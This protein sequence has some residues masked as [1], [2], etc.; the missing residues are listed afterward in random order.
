MP[1]HATSESRQLAE[2]LMSEGRNSE[3]KR[4]F[5]ESCKVIP[6]GVNSPGRSFRHVGG[7]PCFVD[8]ALGCYLTDADGNRYIDY[9]CSWGVMLLGHADP[10]VTDAIVSAVRN[11][12][13]FGLPSRGELSVAA[14]VTARVPSVEKLRLVNTGTEAV[15]S[16]IRLARAATGRI[17]LLKFAGCYH[18]NV[19]DLLVNTGGDRRGGCRSREA[20]AGGTVTHVLPFNDI[21]GLRR[22]F[23][24]NGRSI[25]AVIVEPVAANMGVVPPAAGFLEEL[26]ILC[27]KY[28]SLLI[29][30]E[31]VTGFRLGPSGAQGT[32]GVAPDITVFG[33]T[34][35]GGLPIGAYG[36]PASL[37]DLLAPEGDVYQGGTFCGNPLTTAAAIAT[38]SKLDWAT[39]LSLERRAATLA[40]GL[41]QVLA[42]RGIRA[43]VQRVGSMLSVFFGVEGVTNYTHALAADREKYAWFFRRMFDRGV[44]LPPSPMEAWFVSVAHTD[45]VIQETLSKASDALA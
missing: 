31:V 20:T 9:V 22:F 8:G 34:L 35:G 21:S 42:S 33:K 43:I 15:L 32:F 36:G 5:D 12:T 16:A 4:L 6:G 19:D 11:G 45:A 26:R 40:D 1:S 23:E 29:F 39:Y 13:S 14:A 7:T 18:G 41:S 24:D 28:G 38:L 37:M 17:Q 2:D 10:V 27:T 44:L 3:S 25:A 30:D